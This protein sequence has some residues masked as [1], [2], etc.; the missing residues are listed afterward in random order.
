MSFSGNL[1]QV[2]QTLL[3]TYGEPA[4]FNR[5]IVTGYDP[6]TSEVTGVS[7]SSFTADVYPSN[8]L[9]NEVD[10]V[11]ITTEDTRLIVE[12]SGEPEI[13]DTVTFN[14]TTYRVMN[15]QQIRAQGVDVL[16][17]CQVRI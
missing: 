8:Y 7:T 5:D 11:T 13:N 6:T 10:N 9:N 2:A 3:D 1:K 4:T 17:I 12:A 16:Y 14:N 15:V